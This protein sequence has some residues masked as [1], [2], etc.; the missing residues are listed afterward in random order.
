[1]FW[2]FGLEAAEFF[3]QVLLQFELI[4]NTYLYLWLGKEI[5]N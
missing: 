2:Y 4:D 3:A 1:M 5:R